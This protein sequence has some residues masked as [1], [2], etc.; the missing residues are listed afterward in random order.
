[1]MSQNV[2]NELVDVTYYNILFYSL[3]ATNYLLKPIPSNPTM[4]SLSVGQ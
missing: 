3:N 2:G 4:R 1:M